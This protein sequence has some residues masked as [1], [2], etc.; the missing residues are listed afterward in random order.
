MSAVKDYCAYCG[1]D[2]AFGTGRYVNRL[3]VDEGYAC[4]SCAGFDCDH[5]DRKIPLDEDIATDVGHY[6]EDCYDS[7]IHGLIS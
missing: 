5:C 7:A 1:A 2:T 3:P 4:A 6:H